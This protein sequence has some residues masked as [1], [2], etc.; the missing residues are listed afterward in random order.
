VFSS[1]GVGERDLAVDASADP[2]LPALADGSDYVRVIDCLRYPNA[3]PRVNPHFA[4]CE[5]T[6]IVRRPARRRPGGG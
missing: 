5:R 6:G 2:G 4:R 3:R 1:S